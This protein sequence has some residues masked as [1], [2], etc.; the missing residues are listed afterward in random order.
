MPYHLGGRETKYHWQNKPRKVLRHGT[1]ERSRFPESGLQIL[2]AAKI[3]SS[4][5]NIARAPIFWFNLQN[6]SSEMEENSH[7]DKSYEIKHN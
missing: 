3:L 6:F 5:F 7:R 1:N 4:A 2:F